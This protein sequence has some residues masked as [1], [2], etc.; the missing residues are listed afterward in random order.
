M[1]YV[2]TRLTLDEL[3][4]GEILEVWVDHGEPETSVPQSLTR[5]GFLV[6]SVTDLT[7]GSGVAI[8]VR[9]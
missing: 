3:A 9:S 1:N 2:H 8:R 7:D 6:L 4:A 5:D